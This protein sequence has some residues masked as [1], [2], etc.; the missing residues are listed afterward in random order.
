MQVAKR[1]WPSSCSARKP[2]GSGCIR[3]GLKGPKNIQICDMLGVVKGFQCKHHS[4]VTGA[5]CPADQV[6]PTGP[7]NETDAHWLRL[8][9]PS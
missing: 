2:A 1:I 6:D 8:H 3:K 9:L 4:M 5:S 7:L